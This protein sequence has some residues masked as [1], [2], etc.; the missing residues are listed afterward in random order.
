[1]SNKKSFFD[2]V[3][4]LFGRRAKEAP[5]SRKR[6]LQLESLEAREML[7]AV[8]FHSAVDA[9]E[10]GQI[11]Y[12]RLERDDT[13]GELTVYYEMDW[14]NTGY[15]CSSGWAMNGR[16]F[17]I[18]PGSYEWDYYG[19]ITFKN[20]EKYVDLPVVAH[21]D[22]LIEGNEIVRLSLPDWGYG[23]SF[24]PN[25]Q[26]AEL[27]I[28]DA[29]VPV[30]VWI[31]STQD[32][33]EGSQNG[34]IRLQRDVTT[35]T[36]TV[37][38]DL[39]STN[40]YNASLIEGQ[41]K[42]GIDFGFLPNTSNYNNRGSVTFGIGK[43]FVD[44]PI[45]VTDTYNDAFVEGNETLTVTLYQQVSY[46]SGVVTAVTIDQE[47]KS[48]SVSIIDDEIQQTV[49]IAEVHDAT[50][51]D[52]D[53]Y[54]LLQRT[55]A[56]S[57]LTVYFRFRD[58]NGSYYYDDSYFYPGF[59][60]HGTDFSWLPGMEYDY[61]NI[62]S[63]TFGVGEFFADIPIKVIDDLYVE[64]EETV[65][66]TLQPRTIRGGNGSQYLL[67]SEHQTATIKIHDNDSPVHVWIGE[68]VNATEG[69]SDGYFRIYR[70]N[71]A[72]K[73]SVRYEIDYNNRQ[74]S[75][76]V[77]G[78]A[79]IGTDFSY[80]PGMEN[81]YYAYQG[82]IEFDVNQEYVNIFIKPIDDTFYEETESVRITLLN[83]DGYVNDED[84]YNYSPGLS[85]TRDPDRRTATLS[86][87]DD[88]PLV[89]V[90]IDSKQNATEGGESGY[91]KLKR[92]NTE[93]ELTV[94]YRL[95][96]RNNG[97]Y[98]YYCYNGIQ[99]WATHGADFERLPGTDEWDYYSYTY[100]SVTFAKG[101]SEI[102]IEI[103]PREDT[104]AEGTEHIQLTLLP[105]D[106]RNGSSEISYFLDS[107]H[108]ATATLALY[109]NE[110]VT[111]VGIDSIKNATEGSENGY[112]R[113]YRNNDQGNLTVYFDLD[114]LNTNSVQSGWAQFG[115]DI[116]W[117]PGTNSSNYHGSVTFQN[118]LFYADIPVNLNG[119][120]AWIEGTEFVRITLSNLAGD[121][122]GAAFEIDE[123][124]A[125]A[126]LSIIDNEIPVTVGIQKVQD[127]AEP[128]TNA[129]FKLVRNDASN[130]LTVWFNLDTRNDYYANTLYWASNGRDFEFLPGTSYNNVRGSV[131]FISGQTEIEIEVKVKDD[132]QM[133]GTEI[134]TITLDTNRDGVTY[135]LDEQ[136]NSISL[137]IADNEEVTRVWF[138]KIQDAVEGG[139]DGL[140]QICRDNDS[141]E[142]EVYF[143]IDNRNRGN[144]NT[145]GWGRNGI[146]FA[147]LPGSGTSSD[148]GYVKFEIGQKV[149]TIPISALDDDWVEGTETIQLTLVQKDESYSYCYY[150]DD[151]YA[152]YIKYLIDPSTATVEI[153]ITDN[154]VPMKVWIDQKQNAAEGGQ[155]GFITLQRSHNSGSLTV[156]FELDY[157][158]ID[159]YQVNGWAKNGVD[160][161][162][163]PGTTDQ[164]NRPY[165]VT[166][167]DGEYT[168]TLPIKVT[169][170]IY[171]EG[172]EQ[173]GFTL[174]HRDV[175]QPTYLLDNEQ[176]TATLTISDNDEIINVWL[177]ETQ[178]GIEGLQDGFIRVYRDNA[179]R[180]LEVFYYFNYQNSSAASNIQGWAKHGLDCILPG[181]AENGIR[182]SIIFE[183]NQYYIDIP[184]VVIDDELYEGMESIHLTLVHADGSYYNNSY[185]YYDYSRQG[186]SYII[187]TSRRE[188]T[189]SIEDNESPINIWIDKT[190][191]AIE[192]IENGFIR[193][194]RDNTKKK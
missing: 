38:Y 108:P 51:G 74:Y 107:A 176:K 191:N 6:S 73:L 77:S 97:E 150:Y 1:M 121:G 190:Q 170:D 17:D 109:D 132:Q 103:I 78:W 138:N 55:H 83:S 159:Y 168:V 178:N 14:Q 54:F 189:I 45:I 179:Y 35:V 154:E 84:N 158:N 193:I 160:F 30:N 71:T 118:G 66:I 148:R 146:D 185:C 60:K 101:Q 92:D 164:W 133:E 144:Q 127:G 135:F 184:I 40:S 57:E 153:S 76:S 59:G 53:G 99:G 16:D 58:E 95:N 7:S 8:G 3:A 44:I 23:Y 15:G 115:T 61:E 5:L 13:Q 111:K 124:H 18:L 157:N 166:F 79:K 125:S 75:S 64:G 141:T 169:D 42:N 194:R 94:Y 174:V 142:L 192:G 69:G 90:W 126:V 32:A 171:I 28:H 130:S 129:K 62:G 162:Y 82:Q 104:L 20:N 117:L 43:E 147:L 36:T 177:G 120:D 50:E 182:G 33:T 72:Q 9:T 88:E 48:A 31:H 29:D 12:F 161:D 24:L 27:T 116:H 155:D 2:R 19:Q 186:I 26:S 98:Y 25:S 175:S 110:P 165:S 85:Y 37:E 114:P 137:E 47:R 112:F 68:V 63:V 128:D 39:A 131:T 145:V 167:A 70:S 4:E 151:Y 56:D 46:T 152:Q 80:L 113:L 134:V 49:K 89:N 91:F 22:G 87:L 188:K 93:R 86:L 41:A 181:T 163:L 52:G 123:D 100:G 65:T 105:R 11:G 139:A 21:T 149:I 173:I 96:E 143:R 183:K 187:D 81:Y 106:E 34:Y 122:G 180:K 140:I 136:N 67:D 119:D 172:D 10:D 156:W 102:D